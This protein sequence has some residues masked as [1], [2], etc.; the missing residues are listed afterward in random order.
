[1]LKIAPSIL[2]ADF[3]RLG[4]QVAECERAGAS[5][6][7]FDAMDGHFV[8]N[9]TI[10]PVVLEAVRR[11]CTLRIDAHLMVSE[12]D[13]YVEDF[14]R[15]GA[16]SIIVHIEATPH[17]HRVLEHI[18]SLGKR[19]GVAVNPA[20]PPHGLDEVVN[21]VDQILVMTVN[22]GFGG[23]S[24]IR[25]TLQK[26]ASISER[27]GNRPIEIAVDGG[28]DRRTVRDVVQ[29]GADLLVAGTFIFRHPQ[30]IQQAILELRD[31]AQ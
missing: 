3:S 7:H 2:A 27:R 29:H 13:R 25:G 28:I 17:L 5:L 31:A 20:T 10:G 19:A 12:A 6:I 22:P 30:G 15:A 9:I 16:D 8:P 21:E 18:K 26:I 24:F 23:Q 14:A 11:S 1:M 4:E